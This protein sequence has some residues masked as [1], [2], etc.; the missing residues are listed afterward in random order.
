MAKTGKLLGFAVAGPDHIYYN[1]DAEIVNGKVSVFSLKVPYP[2]AVRYDWAD[3]PECALFNRDELP[4]SSFRTD[5][6]PGITYNVK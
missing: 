3:N 1:A 4:A 5:D 2:V 6:W